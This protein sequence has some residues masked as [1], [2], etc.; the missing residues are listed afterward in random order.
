MRPASQAALAS[1]SGKPG[2]S[3]QL[4][5]TCVAGRSAR[6]WRFCWPMWCHKSPAVA[7]DMRRSF[8]YAARPR[9][10]ASS[11]IHCSSIDSTAPPL[12]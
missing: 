4:A 10:N 11:P 9:W 12:L 1:I 7:A 5:A 8:M 3:V 2:W 6:P